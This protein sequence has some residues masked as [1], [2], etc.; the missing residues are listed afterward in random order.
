MKSCLLYVVLVVLFILLTTLTINTDALTGDLVEPIDKPF[1]ENYQNKELNF[2]TVGDW[3]YE[4]TEP[5]QTIPNQYRVAEAMETWA[6]YYND[7]FIVN[8][9][10]NFYISYAGDHEGV[11]SV[12]DPKWNRV[13]KG[14]Y[15]GRLAEIPWYTVAGN[16]DWYNNVTAQVD[17][18]LNYDSRFFLPS[19][20][21]VHESY[22]GPDKTKVAWIHIDTNLLFY[23]STDLEEADK[24]LLQQQ[25][26]R[27]GWDSSQAKED[28]LKW[29]EDK[30]IEQQDSK[31][32]FV[33]GHHP[34]IGLCAM[35]Y[36]MVRLRPL[37]EKH[38][39]AAYFSGHAH[40]LQIELAKL[41]QPVT[42]FL[43][44]AG[45]RM[46]DRC[47]GQDWGVP[48]K[49]L[50]FLHSTINDTVMTYEYIDST[51]LEPKVV[52]KGVVYPRY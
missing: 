13:W 2:I 38:R 18:S 52:Y 43:S 29:I 31:W 50:G 24:V 8:T 20:F 42:Y 1:V 27:F 25:L 33:V 4:G 48:D 15:K 41:G 10:D 14:V 32:I 3:G 49:V 16:H 37:F 21:Y 45:S 9:G 40:T 39:V 36:Y 26:K 7:D 47:P 6:Q 34:L 44:G 17:Y 22:F 30:L 19:T 28:K 12:D 11:T 46:E 23:N 51:S 5:G 35:Q